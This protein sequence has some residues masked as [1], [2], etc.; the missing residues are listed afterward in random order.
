LRSQDRWSPL[1]TVCAPGFSPIGKEMPIRSVGWWQQTYMGWVDMAV[2]D[3]WDAPEIHPS[4][5]Q[6]GD[7][8]G[9]NK[10]SGRRCIVKMISG[11]QRDPRKWTF[12]SRDTEGLEHTGTFGD[13][14][15]VRRY[16]K[17]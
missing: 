15:L 9:T 6:V 3:W 13:D 1:V 14:D 2:E 7:V 5:I 16:V 8:I 12:F 4:Q 10:P 11:P 17:K